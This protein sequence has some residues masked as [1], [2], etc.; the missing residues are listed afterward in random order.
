MKPLYNFMVYPQSSIMEIRGGP[1]VSVFRMLLGDF[2]QRFPQMAVLLFITLSPLGIVPGALGKSYHIQNPIEPIFA[3]VVLDYL[4]FLF[5]GETP[6]KKFFKRAIS[7]SLWP[8]SRSSSWILFS[9]SWIVVFWLKISG[10]FSR[11]SFFHRVMV[12][13][14]NS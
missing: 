14:Y 6:V 9:Y 13:G 5:S 3:F 8:I 10:P 7:T 1:P 2:H 11:N 12:R 4:D